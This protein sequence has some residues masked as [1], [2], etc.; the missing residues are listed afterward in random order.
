MFL[1]VFLII[2]GLVMFG[3]L[4]LWGVLG[5]LLWLIG[6]VFEIVGDY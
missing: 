3:E 6:V 4:G 2:V 5:G 1:I